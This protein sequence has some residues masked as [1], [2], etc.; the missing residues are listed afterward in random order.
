MI[1]HRLIFDSE[2]QD[3]PT[4]QEYELAGFDMTSLW[5]G[6]EIASFPTDL[7]LVI[8]AKGDDQIPDLVGNPISW[9]V[10]SDRLANILSAN[11]RAG[12]VQLIPAPLVRETDG[13]AVQGYQVLNPLKLVNCLDESESKFRRSARGTLASLERCV[14]NQ[15]S[16]PSDVRLFRLGEMPRA[17]FVRDD[18]AKRTIGKGLLGLAFIR[19]EAI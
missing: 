19:C 3:L 1:Y 4:I 9:F 14:L 2:L 11:E 7:R 16:I 18:V 10:V 6:K 13:A 8:N 12:D 5:K 17:V 15:H